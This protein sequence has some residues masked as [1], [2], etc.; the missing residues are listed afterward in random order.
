MAGRGHDVRWAVPSNGLEEVARAGIEAVATGPP[1]AISPKLARERYPELETLAPSEAPGLIF[2]K[3]FGAILA[4]EMLAGLE[5]IARDWLPD[6][7]MSDAAEFAGHVLAAELGIPSVTKGFGPLIPE[8]KI[9]ATATEVADLF[10][11]RHLD[12]RPYGGA[13]DTLYIDDYP[14]VLQAQDHRHVPHRQLLRPWRDDGAHHW[15]GS[16]WIPEERSEAPLI[17][18]TMGTVFNEIGPLRIVVDGLAALPVRVL[19]TVGPDNDPTALGPQPRHV[20]VERYV[21]HGAVFEHCDL[22]VCHGGS[23]TTL[24]ALTSGLPMLVLPQ[25]ADQ[26]LNASAITSAGAGLAVLP[27][28]LCADAVVEAIVRLLSDESFRE[29]AQRVRDSILEMPTLDEVAEVLEGLMCPPADRCP[30]ASSRWSARP[31]HTPGIGGVATTVPAW[32]RPAPLP[33]GVRSWATAS[34]RP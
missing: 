32:L 19:V 28:L 25:G 15:S 34:R 31:D 7:V 24:G 18:V 3:L 1:L 23:G 16:S 12:P 2:P 14:P 17:Y 8:A 9:A 20:R 22:V 13:Y 27:D 5:L 26:F 29:G 33:P 4:P 11:S 6:L 30:G 21:P 10:R